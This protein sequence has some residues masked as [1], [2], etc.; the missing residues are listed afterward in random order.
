MSEQRFDRDTRSVRLTQMCSKF[1]VCLNGR[2]QK[3]DMSRLVQNSLRVC[4][5]ATI[6]CC[7]QTVAL[8]RHVFFERP[9]RQTRNPSD[10]FCVRRTFRVPLSKLERTKIIERSQRRFSQIQQFCLKSC[11]SQMPATAQGQAAG[12]LTGSLSTL[13]CVQG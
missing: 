4:W 12:T 6:Q 7:S 8:R 5:N 3:V 10:T 2:P 13:K 9:L 1:L 11:S